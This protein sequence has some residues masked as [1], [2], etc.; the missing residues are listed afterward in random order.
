MKLEPCVW[1]DVSD[2]N[3][4]LIQCERK[5]EEGQQSME[6]QLGNKLPDNEVSWQ[7]MT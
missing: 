1:S 7:A 3:S 2:F 4:T 5:V 6:S